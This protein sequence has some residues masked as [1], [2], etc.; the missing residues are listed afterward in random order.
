MNAGDPLSVEVDVKNAGPRDGDEVVQLYLNFPKVSGRT[1][2]RFAWRQTH[3]T[4]RVAK[5]N[6]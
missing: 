2:S 1:D 4:W 5:P 6:M 3:L